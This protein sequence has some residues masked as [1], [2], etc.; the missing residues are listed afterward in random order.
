MS[1]KSCYANVGV[2]TAEAQGAVSD[3]VAVL[4]TVDVPSRSVVAPGHYASVIDLGSGTAVAISTDGVGTKVLIAELLDNYTTIGIDCVAMNANDVICVGAKPLALVDYIAVEVAAQRML[5]EIAI[6]LKEGAEQAQL[7]IPGGELAQLP[8]VIK[9]SAPRRGFDLVGTCIGSVPINRL[10]TG[11]RIEPG[12][13]IIGI[14]SSGVHSNG[15]TLARHVLLKK[16]GLTLDS[17]VEELGRTVGEELLEPTRIYVR[18]VTALLSCD[19]DVRGLA[20]ITS[21]GL[22]NLNR[23][24]NTVAYEITEPLPTLAIFELIQ[25]LG[26]VSDAEMIE[27]FNMG[28]GFCCIVAEHDTQRATELLTEYHPGT[29]RVGTVVDGT[30]VVRNS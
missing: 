3:L 24:N 2:D 13:A 22:E 10:V 19:L 26:E 25:E 7:E 28:T 1:G 18:A 5:H 23:L 30:G 6:G 20:H 21:G 11:S 8:E 9:G 14:P 16:S 17:Y 29:Q 12:D 15:L 27:V 4:Q